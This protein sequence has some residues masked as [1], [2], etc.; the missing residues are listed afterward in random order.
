MGYRYLS[1]IAPADAA[2]E[3][4][5]GS[6]EELFCAAADATLGVMVEDLRTIECRIRRPLTLACDALDLLLFELLQELIYYKDSEALLLR[7][8]NPRV[9]IGE[10]EQRLTG[11]LMGEPMDRS[12]HRLLMD[13]KAV[14]L[15]RLE[16]RAAAGG[17][18]ATVVLD[19]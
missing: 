16:V 1:D 12:K 9:E 8:C 7:P 11:S 15:H 14:T 19:I 13:V 5:G 4:D 10:T 2:F 18:K 3:A 17:W 6:L